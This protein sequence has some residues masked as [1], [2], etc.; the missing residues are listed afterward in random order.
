MN[1]AEQKGRGDAVRT[2][3]ADFERTTEDLTALLESHLKQQHNTHLNFVREHDKAMAIQNA[4]IAS[5]RK[6]CWEHTDHA[7]AASDS[8]LIG[9][10][11]VLRRKFWGR[12]KW[13][14][15]GK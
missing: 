9:Y 3:R 10:T 7:I 14:V 4:N 1:P 5:V 11:E 15:F 13:L 6:S 12:L 2:L 8:N